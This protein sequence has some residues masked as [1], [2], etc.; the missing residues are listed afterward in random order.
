MLPFLLTG[1]YGCEG[2]LSAGIGNPCNRASSGRFRQQGLRVRTV[3]TGITVSMPMPAA[4][5][6]CQ[7]WAPSQSHSVS[8]QFQLVITYACSGSESEELGRVD[9]DILVSGYTFPKAASSKSVCLLSNMR[10]LQN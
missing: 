3:Q 1:T 4:P 10:Q 7:C 9:V 6:T 5:T 8:T 2:Q